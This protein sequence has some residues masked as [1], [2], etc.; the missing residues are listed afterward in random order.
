MDQIQIEYLNLNKKKSSFL[1]QYVKICQQNFL[2]KRNTVQTFIKMISIPDEEYFSE[3]ALECTV[4]YFVK[5]KLIAFGFVH[6]PSFVQVCFIYGRVAVI[7]Y[8]MICLLLQ[9]ENC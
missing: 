4:S 9:I 6:P 5:I 3:T 2:L 1:I 7:R 8:R